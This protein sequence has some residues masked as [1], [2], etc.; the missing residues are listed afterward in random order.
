METTVGESWGYTQAMQPTH[1]ELILELHN[2]DQRIKECVDAGQTI[3]E[4]AEGAWI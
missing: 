3:G 4:T 2:R 1:G